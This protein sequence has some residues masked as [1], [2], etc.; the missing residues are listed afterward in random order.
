[1]IEILKRPSRR[2]RFKFNCSICGI[3]FFAN[4]EDISRISSVLMPD[5]EQCNLFAKIDC[6]ICKS[7]TL[8]STKTLPEGEYE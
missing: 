7:F 2:I 5:G 3:E 4:P 8:T 6:P 1:M